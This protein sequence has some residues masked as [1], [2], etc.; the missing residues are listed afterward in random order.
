MYY[1]PLAGEFRLSEP[2]LATGGLLCEEMG[3]GTYKQYI[4]LDV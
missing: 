4:T 2:P 3:L 1:F